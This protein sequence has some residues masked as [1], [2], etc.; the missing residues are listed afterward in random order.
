M[1]TWNSMLAFVEKDGFLSETYVAYRNNCLS[2]KEMKASVYSF[3]DKHSHELSDVLH[4]SFQWHRKTYYSELEKNLIRKMA[5]MKKIEQEKGLMPQKDVDD[6]IETAFMSSLYMY[7]R[8]L[9]NDRSLM[10]SD[11]ELATAVFVF[12]RNYAYGGMF[13]YN[14]QG[15]FNV[16]YGGI[17]YNHKLLSKKIAYYQSKPLLE[18]FKKAT[19]TNLDFEDFFKNNPPTEEDFIFLDPP[20]DSEFSTYAQN[21][22]TQEDQ[23]RLAHYLIHEC[24]AKWMMII[25]NTPFILSLYSQSHLRIKTFDKKYLVSFMNRNDKKAEHLMIM[26][27]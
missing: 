1:E 26:N 18:H 11:T 15:A 12:I 17:G 27:Y 20:Y 14:N 24:K 8:E 13:R 9:Y 23:R 19:I 16:P 10:Q 6:N 3:L 7:F 5:R 21:T 2:D 4:T 25:K 22:F